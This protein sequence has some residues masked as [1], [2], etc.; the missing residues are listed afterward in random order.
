MKKLQTT[1]KVIEIIY[2]GKLMVKLNTGEKLASVI[3]GR[4]R[5]YKVGDVINVYYDTEL[6]AHTCRC[7]IC[8]GSGCYICQYTGHTATYT[9]KKI[10]LTTHQ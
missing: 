7:F 9:E 6:I 1:G 10:N 8:H 3:N 4:K 2:N 5:N